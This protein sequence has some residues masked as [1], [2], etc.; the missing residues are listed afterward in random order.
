M[1]DWAQA[2]QRRDLRNLMILARL[3]EGSSREALSGQLAVLSSRLLDEYEEAWQDDSGKARA[4]TLLGE[5]DS[6]IRPQLRIVAGGLAT[7]FFGAA[8]LIL[9]ISR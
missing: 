3:S 5:R 9:L 1:L 8:G 7:F 2:F 6:R 4:F